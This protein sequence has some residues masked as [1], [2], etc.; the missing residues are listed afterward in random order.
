MV[1]E[2]AVPLQC[3]L[4]LRSC[5]PCYMELAYLPSR[6][7]Y[8]IVVFQ[9]RNKEDDLIVSTLEL[10]YLSYIRTIIH[11]QWIEW[12]DCQVCVFFGLSTP[13][14][15]KLLP[16]FSI[17][18]GHPKAVGSLLKVVLLRIDSLLQVRLHLDMFSR[19][20]RDGLSNLFPIGKVSLQA[21][22]CSTKA[23][24]MIL[25]KVCVSRGCLLF[26]RLLPVKHSSRVP[27]RAEQH[28]L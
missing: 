1:F 5:R 12:P 2:S 24:G 11:Y 25:P 21:A 20:R 6:T 19:K 18:V 26:I 9:S 16:C 7:A 17:L 13:C 23:N 27:S 22:P 14:L 28:S 8:R 15:L 3:S 10:K 4:F